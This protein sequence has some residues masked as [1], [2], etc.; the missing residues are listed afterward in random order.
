MTELLAIAIPAARALLELTRKAMAAEPS[1][2]TSR[3]E[4]MI[5]DLDAELSSY[6]AAAKRIA[7]AKKVLSR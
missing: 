3:G 7:E 2:N 4:A 6:E 1:I 5:E